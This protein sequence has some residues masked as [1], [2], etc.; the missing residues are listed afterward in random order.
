[1]FEDM[2]SNVGGKIKILAK[3]MLVLGMLASVIYGIYFMT[4]GGEFILFG[5]LIAV[6]GVLGSW[7]SALFI[8]G[9]GQ[10]ITNTDSISSN[11]RKIEKK[12][13]V[14]VVATQPDESGFVDFECPSCKA[15]LSY[16][17]DTLT[18]KS[19]VICPMCDEEIDV[20]KIKR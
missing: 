12:E 5:L 6:G 17:K 20:D 13:E 16:S 7:I 19:K 8:Y 18:K 1:M 14:N 11:T 9:F 4:N 10:I 3:I 2:F 15:T